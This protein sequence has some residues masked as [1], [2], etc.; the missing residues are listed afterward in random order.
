VALPVPPIAIVCAPADIILNRSRTVFDPIGRETRLQ[1]REESGSSA[2]AQYL[3][4][5]PIPPSVMLTR[6]DLASSIFL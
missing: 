5:I 4:F 6:T 2:D 1:L 3:S